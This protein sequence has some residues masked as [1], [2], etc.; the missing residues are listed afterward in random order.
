MISYVDYGPEVIDRFHHHYVETVSNGFVP[1]RDQHGHVVK[2]STGKVIEIETFIDVSAD[3]VEVVQKKTVIVDAS[4]VL[5]DFASNRTINRKRFEV[6]EDFDHRSASYIGDPRAI[7]Q[8]TI[9]FRPMAPFPSQ[10]GMVNAALE[11]L[12]HEVKN[13]YCLL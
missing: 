5:K 6:I 12:V 8:C 2:D 3:V 4:L 11:N 13:H 1:L 9:P 7:K 10:D